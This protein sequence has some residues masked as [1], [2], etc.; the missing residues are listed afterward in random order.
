MMRYSIAIIGGGITGLTAA[1]KLTVAKEQN[2]LPI[3][4]VL[5]E[6]SSRLGGVIQS[7]KIDDFVV[8]HGPDAFL[9]DKPEL[10]NLL[11]ELNLDS[12]ILPINKHNRQAFVAKH[13]KLIPL[14]NGFF[15][16]A[17]TKLWPFIKSPLFTI[18]GKLRIVLEFFLPRKNMST[19][20]S[21]ASFLNRRFGKELVEVAGQSLVGGIYMADINCLSAQSSLSQFTALEQEHGSVIKGLIKNTASGAHTASGARYNLFASLK[22]GIQMLVN[23]LVQSCSNIQ[24]C[25]NTKLLSVSQTKNN[26][27]L[28]NTTKQNFEVD[29][30]VFAL[31]AKQASPILSDMNANLSNALSSIKNSSSAVVNLLYKS[32]D[33]K[34]PHKG[35]G[36]VVPVIENKKIIASGFISQK[37]DHRA[38]PGFEMIR[39]FIGGQLAPDLF[40]QS[41]EELVKIAQDEIAEYLQIKTPPTRTWLSRHK[42]GL[43]IYQ[44]GH[45]E[46]VAQIE[47]LAQSHP[48]LFFAGSSYSG[49]GIPDCIR[50][51]EKAALSVCQ[52]IH[53][54]ESLC[55]NHL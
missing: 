9:I 27:W 24:T 51:G 29:S 32:S 6:A 38:L 4:I 55:L 47:Q 8:E 50:S 44:T 36:F 20:E 46:T 12:Q 31:P 34:R 3:D 2:N 30:V 52:F 22:D 26:K 43:P 40:K 37:F 14:P 15:L 10:K 1:Y 17:P 5:I 35:F 25:S 53:K 54:K 7:E 33:I 48:G 45:K 21:V 28:L 19:D 18:K 42:D 23:C 41:D 39:V 16:A 11:M 49:V 13:D